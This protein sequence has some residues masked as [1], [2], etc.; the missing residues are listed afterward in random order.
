MMKLYIKE[1][2]E[3]GPVK[4]NDFARENLRRSMQEGIET[5]CIAKYIWT[6]WN[7]PYVIRWVRSILLYHTLRA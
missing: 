5:I 1:P 7:A 2:V 6:I 3:D 4:L